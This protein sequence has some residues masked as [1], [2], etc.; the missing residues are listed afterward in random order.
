MALASRPGT[1]FMKKTIRRARMINPKDQQLQDDEKAVLGAKA[2]MA[3]R[4]KAKQQE[5]ML[6]AQA[7]DDGGEKGKGKKKRSRDYQEEKEEMSED[8]KD[9]GEEEVV[10]KKDRVRREGQRKQSGVNEL[11]GVDAMDSDDDDEDVG[12]SVVVK[13]F[14]WTDDEFQEMD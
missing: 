1:Q 8:G 7:K 3:E 11:W 13:K 9:E 12:E 14:K 6:K 4:R 2:M 10:E 5:M